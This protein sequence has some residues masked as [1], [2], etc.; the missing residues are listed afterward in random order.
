MS[1][2]KTDQTLITFS[3][4]VRHFQTVR[5]IVKYLFFLK[6]LSFLVFLFANPP[7][8]I[9][10]LRGGGERDDVAVLIT[11]WFL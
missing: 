6:C 2:E 4:S 1:I 10:N 7:A 3:A 5:I 9:S 11:R 8:P